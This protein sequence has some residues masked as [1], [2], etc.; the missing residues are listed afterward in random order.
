[1]IELI[2]KTFSIGR[3]LLTGKDV[4]SERLEARLKICS[5][6]KYVEGDRLLRCSIC[7]CKVKEKGLV[8]LARYVPTSS[9]GCKHPQGSRWAKAGVD[10]PK[11]EPDDGSLYS[12]SVNDSTE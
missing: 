6:C 1:M 12:I 7:G 5:T 4:S 11:G 8:N 10:P 9:Y 2:A 3:A